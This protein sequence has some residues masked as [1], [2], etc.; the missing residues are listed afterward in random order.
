[1]NEIAASLDLEILTETYAHSLILNEDGRVIGI[2]AFDKNDRAITIKAKKAVILACGGFNANRA[3]MSRY[4][5]VQ[6]M[7]FCGGCDYNT[8]DGALMTRA[9]GGKLNDMR[10][11]T[12]WMVYD[13]ISP[14][15]I[16]NAATASYGGT[17]DD[18][19]AIDMPFILINLNG[20]RFMAET[21]GYKWV[22]YHTNNQPYHVNYIFFDSGEVSN[23]WFEAATAHQTHENSTGSGVAVLEYETLD[24]IA[25]A[26]EV[27]AD[28]L[29]STIERYNG[30]V[31][32]GKDDEFDRMLR[33]VSRLET[34]P[35]RAV[36]MAPRHYTT[37][38]GIAI[39][40]GCRVIRDDETTIPGLYAAGTCCGSVA[41]QEGLYYQGGVGQ[42]LAQGYLTA[43][44]AVAE[45]SWE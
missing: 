18:S 3:L 28:V 38:G 4:L 1:M 33:K 15:T 23:A 21:L 14:T 19:T 13:D 17:V 6:G 43:E 7:G 9:I 40:S 45:Q 8:G 16:Y 31:D 26:M 36:R 5:P 35:F 12:H 10:L 41:E 24:E 25:K 20:E 27:P 37:Y 22:G 30:F 2:H 11:S 29:K 39:D 42:T 32:A 44:A 34:P